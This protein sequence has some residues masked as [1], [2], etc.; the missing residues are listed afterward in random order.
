[1]L[2]PSRRLS[3]SRSQTPAL[4]KG[5]IFGPTGC[6]MSPTHTRKGGRLYRYYVSQSVLKHGPGACPVGR[7][8]AAEI[9]AAVVDQLRGLLRAPEIVVSTWRAARQS[10]GD[11]KEAE[12]GL[13]AA[14]GRPKR[15]G[16]HLFWLGQRP[17]Q[18]AASGEA[19]NAGRAALYWRPYVVKPS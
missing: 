18:P 6:S 8:P 19:G 15:W 12:V 14:L 13:R 9:E 11:I 5:L 16:H 3:R 10:M 7:V 1:V 4:L 2:S 17:G